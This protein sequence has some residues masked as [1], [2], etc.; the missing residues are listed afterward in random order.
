MKELLSFV[1]YFIGM[2]VVTT[3]L[4]WLVPKYG[5]FQGMHWLIELVYLSEVLQRFLVIF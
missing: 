5:V 3:L 4:L 1:M 2:S